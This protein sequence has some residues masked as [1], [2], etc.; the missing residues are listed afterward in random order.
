MSAAPPRPV[1]P[2]MALWNLVPLSARAALG[3]RVPVRCKI[4]GGAEALA[5]PMGG[6]GPLRV[7]YLT[8]EASGWIACRVWEVRDKGT[9][10][11]ARATVPANVLGGLLTRW[12]REFGPGAAR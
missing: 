8:F 6:P 4:A 2:A 5:L 12:A 11:L 10:N 3:A 7:V 9:A 1:T